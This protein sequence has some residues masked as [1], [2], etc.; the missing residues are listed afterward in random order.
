MTDIAIYGVGGFGREVLTLIQDINSAEQVYNL[1]GFF[2]DGV[3][4]G[5][6][7]NGF[8]VL[9]GADDLNGWTGDIA[10]GFVP[11]M[12]LSI[13]ATHSCVLPVHVAFAGNET[14]DVLS[15]LSFASL[16]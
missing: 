7:V 4:K 1:V 9:G 14:A 10:V 5:T 3:T 11:A 15:R 8:P 6:V 12:F 13:A 16:E 2:D